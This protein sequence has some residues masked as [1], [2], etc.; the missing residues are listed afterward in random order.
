MFDGMDE[1]GE[2]GSVD[3]YLIRDLQGGGLNGH[4][5]MGATEAEMDT[6]VRQMEANREALFGEKYQSAPQI[7]DAPSARPGG[8]ACDQRLIA[9]C[10][11][12][13]TFDYAN[14]RC[15]KAGSTGP[16]WWQ[17]LSEGLTSIGKGFQAQSQADI[18]AKQV[19]LQNLAK[20]GAVSQQGY[21]QMQTL[22]AER[23]KQLTAQSQGGFFEQNKNLVI[24]VVL[25][26]V[27]G[28][29][30]FFWKRNR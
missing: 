15:V 24:L 20:Q 11:R 2:I 9:V 8:T 3:P 29:A 13:D 1:F 30:Y 27:G 18:A 21:A 6:F 26:T 12:P 23:A 5:G 22:L 17:S 16:S 28:V 25:L 7:Y 19:Q 4:G 14:C 10:Q